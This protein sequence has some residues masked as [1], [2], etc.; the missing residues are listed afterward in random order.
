[1]LLS[2]GFEGKRLIRFTDFTTP[3]KIILKWIFAKRLVT[4]VVVTILKKLNCSEI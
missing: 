2:I 4:L 3:V 1:M